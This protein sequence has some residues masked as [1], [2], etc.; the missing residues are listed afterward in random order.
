MS[1]IGLSAKNDIRLNATS[2]LDLTSDSTSIK[3]GADDDVTL[4]HVH[5]TGLTLNSTNKMMFN[6]ASQFIQGSS[7]TVL[8]LGA[9]DEIDLT[10]TA[11]DINGTADV[12][13]NATF[14]ANIV[15]TAGSGT[16][17]IETSGSSSV[18]LNASSSMK[19]TVGGSDSHQFVN[20]SDTVLTIDSSGNVD[21]AGYINF[22]GTASSFASISQPRIFRS[23]SSSGS[24][25]FDAFGHLVLQSR[26]DGSNRDIVF[27]T[28]TGGANKSVINSSGNFLV[29]KTTSAT[30]TVGVEIDGAN[31]VGVFTRDSNAPIEANLKTNDGTIINLRKDGLTVGGIG[32]KGGDVFIASSTS[33]HKGL[34]FA[35]G[36]IFPVTN[37]GANSDNETDLGDS[38]AQFKDFYLS[39][40]IT[41]AT[42][43]TQ[44]VNTSSL[45]LAGGTDSN[46]GA[47]MIVYGGSHS[48]L[49]GVVRFR[50]GSSE[51]ARILS[52]GGITFNGDT[53]TANALD[54]YEE[55]VFTPALSI[56]DSTS[57]ITYLSRS[58]EYVKIGKLVFVNGDIQL[59]SKGSS[60]GV[61]KITSLPFTIN[62]R[63]AGTT[64]D[65]GA[66]L[67]AF[68]SGTSGIHTAIGLMG[69]GGSTEISM[70]VATSS[71]SQ[72]NDQLGSSNI[73][74]SF[75]VRFSLTYII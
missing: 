19:F 2:D 14:G 68:S 66:S 36:I 17:T 50:N 41:G 28:G 65:G 33:G 3:F 27:A 42:Q 61:V 48:S 60:S 35:N 22:S 18:N 67:C 24:Y 70:Y 20:G 8:S 59:S 53:A 34:R 56:N 74:D 57:G 23:G 7:A 29:G 75:S 55:G 26:G 38:G 62:D 73:T 5:N 10:A 43:V 31:G 49:A 44:N 71:D 45:A 72:M 47:N 63:T 25:P 4:T 54:D 21:L 64:L 13:G 69:K 15:K 51:T 16:F 58:A 32:T 1:Y 40:N 12:S 11:I 30:N 9:T 39:G 37:S 6:D 46:V 52:G